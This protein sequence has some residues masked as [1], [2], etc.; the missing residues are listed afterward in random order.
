MIAFKKCCVNLRL[1][2]GLL[3]EK[4][5]LTKLGIKILRISEISKLKDARGTYTLII[6]VQSTFSLKI[7]GLGEKKIEKGYYAYT[8]SALGKGSSNLAGRISRHLRKSKKK[9]WHID[10][11][12]C[13]EKVEIKAVLAMIT[14]KRMECEIN[15]H[16]IR[17]LN[18]NIPISNFGSSD[19]L[20]RCKSH[21]LYFKSNNN[22]V[23]KIAKLYLQK[24][25][26]GI[27]VLLNCE[28]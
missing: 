4:E 28:T 6:S 19:C 3:V 1:R 18:P 23:N 10:Y 26:G 13:S 5:K 12:L 8:G 27:F 15:Q 9:R 17:T 20:R 7:G 21:L 25:E 14:E 2:W 11:L 16:L 22:L 24:K